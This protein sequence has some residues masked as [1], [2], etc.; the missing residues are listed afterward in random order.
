MVI[1]AA[2]GCYNRSDKGRGK[3]ISFF[4][5]PNPRI[6]PE[7]K[8][9]AARW[10]FKIGTEWTVK[11]YSF[12]GAQRVCYEHF[13]ES[14]FEAE[15]QTRLGFRRFKRLKPGAAPTTFNINTTQSHNQQ[16][17]K[18]RAQKRTQKKARSVTSSC[19]MTISL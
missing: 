19:W 3:G 6:K 1:C 2:Y 8:N 11:N 4:S 13:E 5:I 9:L 16:E 15:L 18:E 14:C 10:L 7:K 17:R 12:I